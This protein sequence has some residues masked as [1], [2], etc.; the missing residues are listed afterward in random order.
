MPA[1]RRTIPSYTTGPIKLAVMESSR[2]FGNLVYRYLAPLIGKTGETDTFL[3][4]CS[5]PR[6]GAGE[7]KGIIYETVRGC[8]LFIL[9][10]VTNSSLTYSLNQ[11]EVVMSPDDHY[12]DL[13]RIIE[14]ANGKAKRI[15]V[16]I[17]FLYER[18]T[19]PPDDAGI[20]GL[21]DHASG[22]GLYGRCKY[23]YL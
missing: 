20:S 10:D 6:F 17:P 16:I 1:S 19:A 2:D 11:E 21:C 22:T 15:N 5:C 13:K 4:S 7:G 14:A 23:H 3:L 12:Q 18:K 9:T 8:D